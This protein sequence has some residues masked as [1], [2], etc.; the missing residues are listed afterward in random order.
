MYQ[1]EEPIRILSDLHLA[2]P[3]CRIADVSQLAPLFDGVKTL[4]F[5]G[6]TT[7]ERMQKYRE[8]AK[9][10]MEGLKAMAR[11]KGV[12]LVTV[13]GNHDPYTPEHGSLDLC[14]GQVFLT[15]G[16]ILYPSV[17]P[18]GKNAECAE[19]ARE[20]IEKEYPANFRESLDLTLEVSRR[21][22]QE[23]RV[24]QPKAKRGVLGRVKTLLS[25]AW[26]PDRRAVDRG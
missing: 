9:V 5:N 7:E 24:H 8:M 4:I 19:E 21:I 14:D 2:H 26:P 1:F 16:D 25:Q 10:H 15:H 18:W 20:K 12:K 17:S 22:T 11:A 23:M 6:D 13:R 3:G